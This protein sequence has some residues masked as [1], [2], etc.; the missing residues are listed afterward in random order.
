MLKIG[1]KRKPLIKICEKIKSVKAGVGA[2]VSD[3]VNRVVVGAGK[4]K[5]LNVEIAKRKEIVGNIAETKVRAKTGQIGVGIVGAIVGIK[6][7]SIGVIVGISEAEVGINKTAAELDRVKIGIKEVT[8]GKR[9]VIVGKSVAVVGRSVAGV[10][11]KKSEAVAGKNEAR[12]GRNKVAARK[13]R[14][15]VEKSEVI[16]EK[17]VVLVGKNVA[18]VGK[19][20][21]IIGKSEAVVGKTEVIVGKREV[22]VGKSKIKNLEV[23]AQN[24]NER[25][26]LMRVKMWVLLIKKGKKRENGVTAQMKVVKRK[27]EAVVLARRGLTKNLRKIQRKVQGNKRAGHGPQLKKLRNPTA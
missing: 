1:Q 23:L 9:E 2:A 7:I 12:A 11:V 15:A 6:R 14:A 16:A 5:S 24:L 21:I 27:E 26:N 22:L 17:S 18:I 8:A 20:G 10:A 19:S 4:G 13:N 3:A 25:V